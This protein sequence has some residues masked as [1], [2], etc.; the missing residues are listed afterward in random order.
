VWAAQ[1]LAAVVEAKQHLQMTATAE[2]ANVGLPPASYTK[3]L[4]PKG[5]IK[6]TNLVKAKKE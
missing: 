6:S 3:G 4:L 2:T 5:A 1:R